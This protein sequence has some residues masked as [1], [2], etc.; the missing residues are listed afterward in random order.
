M[1]GKYNDL[2]KYHNSEETKP[3]ACIVTVYNS[4]NCGSYWQAFVLGQVI[5]DL[6]W[7]VTYLERQSGFLG[8]NTIPGMVVSALKRTIRLG[9]AA[10]CT[11]VK[12]FYK[13]QKT[14]KN[15]KVIAEKSLTG[16]DTFVLGSDT[17]WELDSDYFLANRKKYFGGKFE[18]CRVISYA[19]SIANTAIGTFAD[20]PEIKEYLN[21]L[22]AISVRDKRTQEMVQHISSKS[23]EIV[24][25]PTLLWT[26]NEYLEYVGDAPRFRYIYLYLFQRLTAAQ[27]EEIRQ[28]A[29]SQNMQIVEG[30]FGDKRADICVINTPDSFVRYMYYAEYIITDTFHGTVFSVNFRKNFV[31]IDRQKG[32]V[33]EFLEEI[34]LEDRLT[35]NNMLEILR[36][37]VGYP[38]VETKISEFRNRSR[39]YLEKALKGE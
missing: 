27:F 34:S 28:F 2:M 1:E 36:S 39:K 23:A 22:D 7:H 21:Q 35:E 14:Q 30:V 5:R 9:V 13:F 37:D 8:S 6:G 25:D 11:V 31:S 16:I 10:G 26:K 33:N 20:Y 19:P 18:G 15:F 17:I 32:K 4:V 38:T 12:Q 29:H 24:C 3:N